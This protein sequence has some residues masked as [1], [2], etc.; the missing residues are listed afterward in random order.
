M[1]RRAFLGLLSASTA[2]VFVPAASANDILL[3]GTGRR[4][5]RECPVAD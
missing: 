4:L 2:S 3:T 5:A 1:K